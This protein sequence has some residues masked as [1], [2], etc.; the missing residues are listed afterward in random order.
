[1]CIL[2]VEVSNMAN[3]GTV[4]ARIDAKLKASAEAV[5]EDLG[6]SPTDAINIYYRQIVFHQGIPF[7]LSRPK[8]N[9]E[10]EEAITEARAMLADPK[11]RTFSSVD[12]MFRELDK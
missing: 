9:A 4:H 11:L 1:M 12:D 5:L 7:K 2:V 8:Y 10:T 3:A 6:I